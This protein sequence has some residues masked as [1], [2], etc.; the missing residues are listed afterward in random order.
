M[1]SYVDE[2]YDTEA[3]RR[4]VPGERGEIFLG[5][6]PWGDDF[7]GWLLAAREKLTEAPARPLDRSTWH[8]PQSRDLRVLVDVAECASA[9][10]AVECLIGRLAGNQIAPLPSGPSGLGM[11]S[12][13]HPAGVPPAVFFAQGNLCISVVSLA[14]ESAEVLPWA[15]RLHRRLAEVPAAH[16]AALNLRAEKTRGKPGDE[17]PFTCTAPWDRTPESYFKLIAVGGTLS[18][19]DGNLFVKP[20]RAGQVEVEAYLF[21]RGREVVSGQ[22]SFQAE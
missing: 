6:I 13:M 5:F 18:R 3:L 15:E 12:F 22:I 10:D 9:E 14:R 17:L 1:S 20:A 19:R 2:H 4:R 11:A 21:E 7:Q 8:H 16:R